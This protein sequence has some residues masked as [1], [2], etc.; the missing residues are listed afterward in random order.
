MNMDDEEFEKWFEKT[1]E[2]TI[3]ED[4]EVLSALSRRRHSGTK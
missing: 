2:E 1:L 4:R 3:E